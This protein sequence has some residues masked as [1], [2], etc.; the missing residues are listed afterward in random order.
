LDRVEF[1]IATRL[2]EDNR[3]ETMAFP[4]TVRLETM[5]FPVTVR[6]ETM[7]FPVTV[8]V[9]MLTLPEVVRSESVVFPETEKDVAVAFES[10]VFPKTSARPMTMTVVEL[11]NASP[12]T[13]RIPPTVASFVKNGPVTLPVFKSNEF[14]VALDVLPVDTD[15][16]LADNESAVSP[17]MT[18][19]ELAWRGPSV[20][21]RPETVASF[22][23]V[24]FD[25]SLF[26][27]TDTDTDTRGPY[28]T[29]FP[30]TLAV[31]VT[32]R[33]ETLV[34][35]VKVCTPNALVC[36]RRS[37]DWKLP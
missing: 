20:L 30:E 16:E 36:P 28:N 15:S 29:V 24:T 5:A 17:P 8:K 25:N 33:F 9:D 14:M 31:P 18:V 35:P 22:E 3:L 21:R 26:P 2:P 6:L 4:V 11:N 7:A 10:L 37:T 1:P 12:E 32:L 23:T 34:F 13:V 27:V 19:I